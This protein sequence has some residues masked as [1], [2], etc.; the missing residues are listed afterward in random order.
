MKLSL[1]NYSNLKQRIIT[2]S[3]GALIVLI[4]CGY[5]EWTYF[6]VFF[7]ICGATVIEFYS[8]CRID[9]V[10]SSKPIG[11]L[12]SLY[13]FS[14]TFLVEKGILSN[15]IYFTIFPIIVL[16]YLNKLYRKEEKPFT[17]IAYTLMGIT[18]VGL[19]FALLNISVFSSGEYD[20]QIPI[21]LLMIF[22]AYDSGA[23]FTGVRFGKRRLFERI[24]PKKSWEGFA[25]GLLTA[26][27]IASVI[28]YY[29]TTLSLLEWYGFAIIVVVAGTY[30]DLVESLFKR[31]ISIKDSGKTIPGHGGFLDRFDGL[32]LA[33]PFIVFYM[34]GILF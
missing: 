5:N 16:V 12:I 9:G 17:N 10:I 31:S 2:G 4:G 11:T 13:I 25:G 15:Y 7:I 33:M 28:G 21:G 26:L 24:S 27:I 8:L 1:T 6:L 3:I 29:F 22:W 34:K 23:Y 18:Y 30:G 19:P 32:L 14:L 20:Y